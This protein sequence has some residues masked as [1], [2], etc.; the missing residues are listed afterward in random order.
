MSGS[1]SERRAWVESILGFRFKAGGDL[2]APGL[3]RRWEAARQTWQAAS[4]TVDA[5]IS[6]LRSA[7]LATGDPELAEIA[8]H[9]LNAMTIEGPF[10]PYQ[11]G[12]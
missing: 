11:P 7:F 5:Q 3:R 8:E 6:A 4:E 1:T 9:G 2:S 10:C 12:C